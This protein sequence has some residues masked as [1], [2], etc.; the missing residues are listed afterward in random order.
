MALSKQLSYTSIAISINNNIITYKKSVFFDDYLL[1]WYDIF[2]VCYF[3]Y[4]SITGNYAQN[5]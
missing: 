1:K 2:Y 5:I 4:I 3:L